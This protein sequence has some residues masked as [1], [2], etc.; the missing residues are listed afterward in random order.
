M[1]DFGKHCVD[2]AVGEDFELNGR[3]ETL[4]KVKDHHPVFLL[5]L[6]NIHEGIGGFGL[7]ELGLVVLGNGLLGLL[8]RLWLL[9]S[10]HFGIWGPDSQIWL[11]RRRKA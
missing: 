2:K 10:F 9:G 7:G 8:W 11:L 3:V 4:D 1:V 5:K 6:E